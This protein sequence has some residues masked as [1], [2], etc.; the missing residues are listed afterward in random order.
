MPN[1]RSTAQPLG[2]GAVLTPVH[3]GPGAEATIRFAA[4]LARCLS[5]RLVGTGADQLDLPYFGDGTGVVDAVLVEN[6]RAVVQEN[7]A[8][9]SALF[10][11]A[12]DGVALEWRDA[13]E[14]PI[15]FTL[16]QSRAADLVVLARQGQGDPA[17]GRM[18]VAP[19]DIVLELGRPILLVPPAVDALMA[20]SVVIAWKDTRESRRA[21]QDALPFLV[22]AE[23]V[24]VLSVGADPDAD[25]A[26][27]VCG[28]LAQ[29]GIAAR[30]VTRPAGS[31]I[32]DEITDLVRQQGAD[33][34]VAG[35]YGHS[36]LREWIFGG[37]TRDLIE[38]TP[39][40]CLM[41]H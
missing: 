1:A 12:A 22:R 41:S 7:L 11:R 8:K 40:C 24:S 35:A 14:Q 19:G 10:H 2:F 13:V 26:Q 39:V 17:L 25:G 9:A 6:A 27:D 20:R 21:V 16:S 30:T 38:S 29:Y 15:S 28:Y 31:D 33:L 23:M 34:I 3:L 32:V 36:R 4:K 37:V 18:G 5:C